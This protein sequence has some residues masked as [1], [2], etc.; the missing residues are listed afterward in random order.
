MPPLITL[1]DYCDQTGEDINLLRL[2]IEA[3]ELPNRYWRWLFRRIYVDAGE[4]RRWREK[5]GG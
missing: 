1:E 5:P 2:L 4:L 3:G